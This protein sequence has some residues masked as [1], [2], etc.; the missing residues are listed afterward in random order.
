[1]SNNILLCLCF[2][3]DPSQKTRWKFQKVLDLGTL[4]SLAFCIKGILPIY[5]QDI[6]LS[7]GNL[8]ATIIINII[9]ISPISTPFPH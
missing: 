6:G 3:C 7:H 2:T 1:M 9:V 5:L 4:G 8:Y